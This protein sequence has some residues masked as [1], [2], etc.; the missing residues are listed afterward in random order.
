MSAVP[1]RPKQAR[2]GAEGEGTPTNAGAPRVAIVTGAARG[3][4]RAIA[5][6]L[7]R[8]GYDVAVTDV[9]AAAASETAREIGSEVAAPGVRVHPWALNVRNGDE[10]HEVFAGVQRQLGTPTALVNNAGIWSDQPMLDMPEEVWTAT[11]DVNLNGPF[12][13]TQQFGRMRRAEGGGGA[14]VNIASVSAFSA[15]QGASHYA[16]SKAAIV[17]FTK[18]T[19]W[20]LGA[21][22]IRVNAVAPGLIVTHDHFGTAAFREAAVRMM[23]RGRVGEPGDVAGAVAFLLSD[24]ADFITG[25]CLMVDG[26]FTAGRL[27]PLFQTP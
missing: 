8:Q 17:M 7:A 15:R 24:E 3:L 18:S 9:D 6:R 2:T 22:G 25:D 21:H 12:R 23:P 10:V 1:G 11:L 13:C 27:L 5:E 16:A 20:E 14:I 19:A 4:G 26:G